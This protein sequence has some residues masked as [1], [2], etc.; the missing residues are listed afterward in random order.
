ME[1]VKE[2]RIKFVFKDKK[3]IC[4]NIV[5]DVEIGVLL[6]FGEVLIKSN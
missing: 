3:D 4:K 6:I 2:G 1:Y 5:I